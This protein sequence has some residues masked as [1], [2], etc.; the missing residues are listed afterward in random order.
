MIHW[1]YVKEE[2]KREDETLA[3]AAASTKEPLKPFLLS[4][5]EPE[6]VVYTNESKV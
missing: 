2:K 1:Q 3:D 5:P 6:K 4:N